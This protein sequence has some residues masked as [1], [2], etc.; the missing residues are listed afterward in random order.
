MKME[1]RKKRIAVVFAIAVTAGIMVCTPVRAK[2]AEKF[3]PVFYASLYSDVGVAVGLDANALYDHYVTRGRA[4]GR[5]PCAGAAAG[6]EVDGITETPDIT[7]LPAI[8]VP[9]I[10]ALKDLPHYT[11]I[12]DTLTDE[13]LTVIYNTFAPIMPEFK[14]DLSRYEQ[15]HF[16]ASMFAD[17][18]ATGQVTYSDS[19][20]F[21]SNP[22]SF[23]FFKIADSGG[24]VRTL[25]LNLD[26]LGIEW[27]HLFLGND[28]E[29]WYHWC[30]A[31][32]DGQRYV[33]DPCMNIFR[34]EEIMYYHPVAGYAVGR[35]TSDN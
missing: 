17:M 9:G 30:V 18:Y 11:D 28:S 1:S 29:I 15:V 13:E 27:E 33:V 20:P 19:T 25:G 35:I 5:I 12:K 32:I 3:D 23:Y 21:F 34:P 7:G 4:E 26:M 10:V 6:A 8:S 14:T 2:A 22:R 31:T 24:C 16:F